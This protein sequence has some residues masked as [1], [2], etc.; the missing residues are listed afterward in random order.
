MSRAVRETHPFLR[1]RLPRALARRRD[2][3]SS[4]SAGILATA[5]RHLAVDETARCALV[6][7]SSVDG[8]SSRNSSVMIGPV[9]LSS[10]PP[11]RSVSLRS[12]NSC[13]SGPVI[14]LAIVTGQAPIITVRHRS[15]PSAGGAASDTGAPSCCD[16][17][18][19]TVSAT[20]GALRA[21][22]P[23]ASRRLKRMAPCVL[24]RFSDFRGS[25]ICF[26]R[27]NAYRR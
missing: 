1:A 12:S 19:E 2:H 22:A 24:T 23:A 15:D 13:C 26:Y 11:V 4:P 10:K 27:P 21:G 25:V 5:E 9:G 3:R 16:A 7:P 14:A 6:N 8:Q 17:S 18:S 20:G